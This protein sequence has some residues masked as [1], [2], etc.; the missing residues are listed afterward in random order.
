MSGAIVVMGV[1]GCGKTTL[2]S[3]LADALGWRF[4]EGD[5][6]HPREN[7]EKMA[8]G[9]PLTDEDRAPFLRNVAD[10]IAADRGHGVI[11]ACSALKRS[12]RDL[13]RSRAGA[14]TF[15]LPQVDSARLTA[16]MAHRPGHFMPVSLLPSQLATLEMPGA[17]EQ[18]IVIDGDAP[19]SA[20]VAKV[21]A[22]LPSDSI[23]A[24]T[25][26]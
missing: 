25:A 5:D 18:V 14:V 12:Y 2:G 9:I 23:E 21:I 15:V 3:A 20:Q 10:A 22:A 8:A 26:R 24:R 7:V 19:V 6:L 16:R 17:D 4:V 13:I 11:A 1:S